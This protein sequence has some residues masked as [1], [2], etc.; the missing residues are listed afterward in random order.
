MRWKY[1][2][3][4]RPCAM[5]SP[6]PRLSEPWN[7]AGFAISVAGVQRGP[8]GT[9]RAASRLGVRYEGRDGAVRSAHWRRRSDGAIARGALGVVDVPAA[10]GYAPAAFRGCRGRPALP[11]GRGIGRRAA[12]HETDE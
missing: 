3:T 10:S 4:S 5:P 1:A 7:L 2:A 11:G 8:V 6:R 9:L 12:R